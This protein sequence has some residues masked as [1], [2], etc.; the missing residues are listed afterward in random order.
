VIEPEPHAPD[1]PP[2][3][4]WRDL[5]PWG[6]VWHAVLP[7]L[8]YAFVGVVVVSLLHAA[9]LI[10]FAA[11]LNRSQAEEL[12]A[13]THYY[14]HEATPLPWFL[15]TV[16][17]TAFFLLGWLGVNETWGQENPDYRAQIDAAM[18]EENGRLPPV[19]TLGVIIFNFMLAVSAPFAIFILSQE[20]YDLIH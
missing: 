7:H 20:L 8:T 9:F 11:D 1:S 19:V 18:N 2:Q 15:V 13:R 16:A 5:G 3:R 6:L 10:D 17:P 12:A 14:S 4:P